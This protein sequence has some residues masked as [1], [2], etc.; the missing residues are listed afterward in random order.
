MVIIGIVVVVLVIAVA[1]S[2]FGFSST[3]A[4]FSSSST[5]SSSSPIPATASYEESASNSTVPSGGLNISNMF[6]DVIAYSLSTPTSNSSSIADGSTFHGSPGE[7]ISVLFVVVY[8]DCSLQCPSEITSV[9]ASTPGFTVTGT[10]PSLPVPFQG[11]GYICSDA[12]PSMV[13]PEGKQVAV[14]VNVLTPSTPYEGTL[15]LVAQT[16]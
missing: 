9:T 11:C 6:A 8:Q 12:S 4:S 1:Y 16:A 2:G 15:T 13:A 3:R 14:T 10:A 7:T 5:L